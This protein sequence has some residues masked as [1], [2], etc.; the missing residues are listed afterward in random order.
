MACGIITLGDKDIVIDT[1]LQGL[2]QWYRL[3]HELL[4]NPAKSVEARLEFHVMIAVALCDGGDYG[5]VVTFRADV[6]R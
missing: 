2:V 6:M 4:F 3:A 1:R 5:D